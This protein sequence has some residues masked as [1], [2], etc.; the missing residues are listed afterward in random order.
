VMNLPL[1]DRTEVFIQVRAAGSDIPFD[2]DQSDCAHVIKE[3][4]AMVAEALR[5]LRQ[6]QRDP[7]V[8]VDS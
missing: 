1:A 6:V 5:V 2:C 8:N 3:K 7:R 4:R